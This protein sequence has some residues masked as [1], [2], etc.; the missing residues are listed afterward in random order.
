MFKT[1]ISICHI[2]YSPKVH[3]IAAPGGAKGPYDSCRV[4][5]SFV[6]ASNC[7]S[8]MNTAPNRPI[9]TIGLKFKTSCGV[10]GMGHRI[11]P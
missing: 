10:A 1:E 2:G 8:T 6:L 4:D 5:L 9:G 11:E 3:A 7:D